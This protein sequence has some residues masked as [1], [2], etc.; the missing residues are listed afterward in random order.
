MKPSDTDLWRTDVE[1][2]VASLETNVD[3]APSLTDALLKW[4]AAFITQRLAERKVEELE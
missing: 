3:V 4:A 2:L 1:A